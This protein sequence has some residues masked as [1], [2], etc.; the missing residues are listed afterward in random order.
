MVADGK[1]NGRGVWQAAN[2]RYDGQWVDDMQHGH[3]RQ[4]WSD[5][6]IF[7]GQFANGKFEGHGHMTWR[8]SEGTLEYEGEYKNDLKHGRGRFTWADGRVYD[9]QW[10]E[11]KRHGQALYTNPE[12]Q[13]KPGFWLEDRFQRWV[14]EELAPENVS[15]NGVDALPRL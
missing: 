5:G 2:G 7:E 6:R 15:A 10:H 4:T 12:G 1:R 9:G 14:Q 13:I 11:G 3:G 8:V